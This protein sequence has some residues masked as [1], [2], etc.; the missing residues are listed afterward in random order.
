MTLAD[1]SAEHPDLANNWARANDP[2]YASDP[3]AAAI[4]SYGSLDNYLRAAAQNYG[5]TITTP[6]PGSTGTTQIH[7][8]TNAVLAGYTA[9]GY[10]VYQKYDEAGWL[11][12]WWD[13]PGHGAQAI[14]YIR[15]A[16]GE[17]Y[18]QSYI[19]NRVTPVTPGGSTTPSTT[20]G[21]SDKTAIWVAVIGAVGLWIASRH[22]SK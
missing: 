12:E 13:R 15:T 3:N 14:H 19:G 1:F 5:E 21:G 18:A 6:A 8:P 10:E 4:L 17:P 22:S 20:S 16:Q 11:V 2:Q 7:P 9:E